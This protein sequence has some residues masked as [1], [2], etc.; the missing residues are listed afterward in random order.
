MLR[1][2][3]TNSTAKN[4]LPA[5]LSIDT[6]SEKY[7]QLRLIPTGINVDTN[8]T[9]IDYYM[10][11]SRILTTASMYPWVSHPYRTHRWQ[12]SDWLDGWEVESRVSSEAKLKSLCIYTGWG[13]KLTIHLQQVRRSTKRGFIYP[14]IRL[15][16]VVHNY[17]LTGT[18]LLSL[19][20][21]K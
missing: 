16:G 18:I 1:K 8:F 20:W 4:C 7:V 9:Y 21:I 15:H 3:F 14:S 13:V 17:L 19:F 12:P 5:C 2:Q 6:R 11:L 10:I